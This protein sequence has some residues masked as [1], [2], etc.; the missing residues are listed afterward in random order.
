VKNANLTAETLA[1]YGRNRPEV[2][3]GLTELL[4][5]NGQAELAQ[6]LSGN[7]KP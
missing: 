3:Q 2:M 7:P 1:A 4:N 6:R 5:R